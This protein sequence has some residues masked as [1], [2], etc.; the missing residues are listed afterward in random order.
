MRSAKA[1]LALLAILWGTACGKS[2]SNSIV[3]V[4]VTPAPSRPAVTQLRVLLKN[5]G[6]SDTLLF[7]PTNSAAQ[8]E[9]NALF[10]MT[11]PK[12]RSGE[13]DVDIEALDASS[14]WVAS[15]TGRVAIVVGGRAD[16]LIALTYGGG[17]DAGI[18]DSGLGEVAPNPTEAGPADSRVLLDSPPRD[19]QVGRDSTGLGG[20]GGAGGVSSMDARG[21]SG[22]ITT[23]TGGA[24]TGPGGAGMGGSGAGGSATGGTTTSRD[25]GGGSAAGGTTGARDGAIPPPDSAGTCIS[26]VVSNGYACGSTPACSACKDQNGN[27]REAGC[28]K[29]IDCLAT[30]GASCDSNCKQNCLNLAGDGPAMACVTALQTAACGAAGCGSTPPPNGGG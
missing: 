30:A 14:M 13:L 18:L 20:N 4:T 12:S 21:D 10:A 11:F 16:A 3:V 9:F 28:K 23:G 6:S 15:G 8:I 25:G 27:S 5:A 22:G 29:V 19:V 26:Q 2:T 7:P 24:T 1:L 17:V